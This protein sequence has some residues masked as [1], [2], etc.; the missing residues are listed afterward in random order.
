[1]G[2]FGQGSEL[3]E[4][5]DVEKWMSQRKDTKQAKVMDWETLEL[6]AEAIEKEK[7]LGVGI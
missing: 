2:P 1:M 7:M 3:R 4:E 6:D 5:D